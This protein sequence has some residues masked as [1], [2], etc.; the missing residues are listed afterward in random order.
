[1]NK[2]NG[3]YYT[4]WFGPGWI[5]RNLIDGNPIPVCSD[6]YPTATQGAIHRW[7]TALG[8]EAFA[9]SESC[10]TEDMG[11]GAWDL[12]AGI[13]SVTVSRG[14]W[15]RTTSAGNTVYEGKLET[16]K[17][18]EVKRVRCS[19]HGG[20]GGAD[21]RGQNETEENEDWRSYHG[22]AQVIMNPVA[23]PTDGDSADLLRGIT[24][25]L[26]GC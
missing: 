8:I 22:R 4:K 11:V 13:I 14:N 19:S 20:C 12:S 9:T 6:D 2:Y 23:H 3:I 21:E 15:I 26:A 5:T 10:I 24:H 1:M 17:D 7:N 25:E 18:G 16:T